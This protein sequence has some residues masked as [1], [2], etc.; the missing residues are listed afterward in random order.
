MIIPVIEMD[1][2]RIADI[3]LAH[4]PGGRPGSIIF[5]DKATTIKVCEFIAV[6]LFEV[7]KGYIICDLA[8]KPDGPTQ[9]SF[10]NRYTIG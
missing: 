7:F 6:H 2:Q 3:T 8:D 1:S 9:R 5:E 10:L 4:S